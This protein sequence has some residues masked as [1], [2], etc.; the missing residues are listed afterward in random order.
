MKE[1]VEIFLKKKE[2]DFL[3]NMSSFYDCPFLLEDSSGCFIW[4]NIVHSTYK[5]I[6][7]VNDSRIEV[8]DINKVA[9]YIR[10]KIIN[11]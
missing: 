5:R 2:K 11:L 3:I 1:G 7:S 4:G 9:T 6:A 8:Y 10:S